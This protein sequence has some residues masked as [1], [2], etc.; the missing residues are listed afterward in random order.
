M[1]TKYHMLQHPMKAEKKKVNEFYKYINGRATT[2][3]I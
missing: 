1:K 2:Y 3:P